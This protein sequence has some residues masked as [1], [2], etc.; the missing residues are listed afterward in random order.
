MKGL[1]WTYQHIFHIFLVKKNEK[2]NTDL[3]FEIVPLVLCTLGIQS[4]HHTLQYCT[5][6][7]QEDED[8][9]YCIFC[10]IMGTFNSI[11]LKHGSKQ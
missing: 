5:T 10:W 4:D 1:C 6:W 2:V 9:N 7:L 8:N 3:K 11:T